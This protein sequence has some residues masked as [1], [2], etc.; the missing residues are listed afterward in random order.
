MRTYDFAPLW[1]S[2]V[3]FDRLFDLL[4]NTQMLEGQ[5]NYPP[6]DIM[7]TGED[8]YRISLAVAG[9]SPDDITVTAQQNLLTVAGRKFQPKQTEHAYLYL[10]PGVRAAVQ[11]RRSRRSGERFLRKRA[12]ADQPCSEDSGS[13]EASADPDQRRRRERQRQGRQSQDNRSHSRRF[14]ELGGTTRR[15]L[16]VRGGL[17]PQSR[18][19]HLLFPERGE[20]H[21]S[22]TRQRK[23]TLTKS[24]DI[25]F[26]HGCKMGSRG[27]SRSAA[28]RP[29]AAAARRT[30]S[31]SASPRGIKGAY[32]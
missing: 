5:D 23:P 3:G 32:S 14:I 7:R 2:T 24:G 4:N 12:T 27:S 11:P 19:S 1:R 26:R 6:Y 22:G 28:D 25:V 15:D 16:I 20:V 29:T 30:G 31:R 9:F 13:N 17:G 21:G 18:S 8:T 10:R